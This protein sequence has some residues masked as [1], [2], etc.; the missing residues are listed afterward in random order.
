MTTMGPTGADG[1]KENINQ[2]AMNLIQ[3]RQKLQLAREE[4]QGKFILEK[5]KDKTLKFTDFVRT[6]KLK[7]QLDE[8]NDARDELGKALGIKV[9]SETNFSENSE[10]TKMQ[11]NVLKGLNKNHETIFGR[12]KKGIYSAFVKAPSI[13]STNPSSTKTGT[14]Q[15]SMIDVDTSGLNKKEKDIDSKEKGATKKTHEKKMSVSDQ[16]KKAEAAGFEQSYKPANTGPGTISTLPISKP[17]P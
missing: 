8:V 7:S 17:K 4:R 2:K 13:T 10:L 11:K 6:N 1:R 5:S 15:T 3:A 16:Q 12:A 9:N 14:V